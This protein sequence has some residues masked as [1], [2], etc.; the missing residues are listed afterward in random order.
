MPSVDEVVNE[1]GRTMNVVLEGPSGTGKTFMVGRVAQ[2]WEK[3][4]SR[5]L[6]GD[7]AGSYALVLHPSTSYEDFIEGIRPSDKGFA[8]RDGFFTRAVGDALKEPKK[9]FVVL[10][11]EINRSNIPRVLGDLL[12]LLERDKR[13]EWNG[14]NW[15]GGAR[16]TLP[17]SQRIF[18]VPDNVYVI[19]TM[20]SS[21]R[22][23]AG[24]DS[25]LRRRFSFIRIDPLPT[26]QWRAA[27]A[28]V[29][30]EVG[31]RV[32]DAADTI[33]RLNLNALSPAVGADFTLGHSYLFAVQQ[34]MRGS[35]QL[36]SALDEVRAG[37]TKGSGQLIRRAFWTETGELTGGSRNQFDLSMTGRGEQK[38][39]QL[40]LFVRDGSTIAAEIP[41][42]NEFKTS[43]E[44]DGSTYTGNPIAYREGN[45]TWRMSLNGVNAAGE[46]LT[47]HAGNMRQSIQVWLETG[48][49]EFSLRIVPKSD[50][51]RRF[52]ESLSTWWDETNGSPARAYGELSTE[53]VRLS[54]QDDLPATW[55][56]QMGPQLID[57]LQNQGAED[58]LI[59]ERR[60]NWLAARQ[61]LDDSA[62]KTASDALVGLDRHLATLGL[63]FVSEGT[64]LSRLVA[65]V[66]VGTEAAE[67]A[68]AARAGDESEPSPNAGD[69]TAAASA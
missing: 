5:P 19:A 44:F 40:S 62:R 61:E 49:F 60:E 14:S 33:A 28:E 55:L 1:L 3:V 34:G 7:G 39:G 59:A 13:A 16:L 37:K 36:N 66:V 38:R 26:D 47:P 54:G 50:P 56:Y 68:Q 45:G 18:F 63:Q 29:E 58:L 31:P 9:D 51:D 4:T 67:G 35:Q 48:D 42:A 24:L 25:A 17:Y 27:L 30:P 69:T 23:I 11:D 53:S 43:V 32:F 57:L 52:L 46:S 65:L 10:L 64:G 8:L 15:I 6:G 2:R 12:M 20:N 41:K 21:D 22:S